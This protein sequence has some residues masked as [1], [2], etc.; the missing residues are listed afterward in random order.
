MYRENPHI[1]IDEKKIEFE[2]SGKGF[3]TFLNCENAIYYFLYTFEN[4]V[5]KTKIELPFSTV[6][7]GHDL[8]K[9]KF[10]GKWENFF[11]ILRLGDFFLNL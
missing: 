2:M 1:P 8:I 11:L 7:I 3:S 10:R 9:S 6:N 4:S 5:S